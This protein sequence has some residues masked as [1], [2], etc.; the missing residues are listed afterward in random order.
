M[1]LRGM[2][3]CYRDCEVN[4][5]YR[6]RTDTPL[7]AQDFES[8]ASANSAKRPRVR[9]PGERRILSETQAQATATARGS[10]SGAFRSFLIEGCRPHPLRYDHASSEVCAPREV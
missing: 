1:G 4:G 3:M 2:R 9:F 8:S 10:L 7:R 5:L 6:S